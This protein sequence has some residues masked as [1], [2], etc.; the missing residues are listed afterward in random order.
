MHAAFLILVRLSG[1]RALPGPIAWGFTMVA[2]FS[3]WLCFYELNTSRMLSKLVLLLNPA[4]YAPGALKATIAIF[5]PGDR[6]VL[7][8]LFALVAGVLSLEW[9]SIRRLKEPYGYFRKKPVLI[10]LVVL[11]VLL[12]P[13][14]N[15]GFIYFAF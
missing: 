4:A 2:A 9:L 6:F 5:P 8:G 7:A 14:K 13:G 3:A 1:K 12:A 10:L 15:N 11:T